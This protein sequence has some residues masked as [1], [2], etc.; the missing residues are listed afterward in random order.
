MARGN[1]PV[2]DVTDG[3]ILPLYKQATGIDVHV[4][5]IGSGQ[6]SMRLG[7]ARPISFLSILPPPK[8]NSPSR[9][10]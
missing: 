7:M 3:F 2:G 5:G 10:M 4:I 8:R 9:G 6:D 1:D